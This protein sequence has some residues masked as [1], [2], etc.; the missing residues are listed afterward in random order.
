[1]IEFLV[2]LS[3]YK[4]DI[5]SYDSYFTKLSDLEYGFNKNA[6]YTFK[7]S[8]VSS[9]MVFGLATHNEINQIEHIKNDQ[10]YCQGSYR[11]SQ[12]QFYIISDNERKGQI[13]SKSILIPYVF[14]C[15]TSYNFTLELT[16]KNLKKNLDYRYQNLLIFT[17]IFFI[18]TFIYI[19]FYISASYCCSN[20]FGTNSFNVLLV[21]LFITFFIQD[22]IAY[23]YFNMRDNR[24]YFQKDDDKISTLQIASL[25]CIFFSFVFIFCFCFI[26]Y[27]NYRKRKPSCCVFI[28]F[29]VPI[30]C[31]AAIVPMMLFDN[32]RYLPLITSSLFFIFDIF[33]IFLPPCC[34]LVK[35]GFFVY[36]IGVL[37]SCPVLNMILSIKKGEICANFAIFVAIIVFCVSQALSEFLL[38]INLFIKRVNN[39]DDD[40]GNNGDQNSLIQQPHSSYTMPTIDSNHSTSQNQYTNIADS[41]GFNDQINQNLGLENQGSNPYFNIY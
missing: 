37:L 40:D 31:L 10:Q 26:K 3:Y 19:M 6:N 36:L 15:N 9:K 2:F 1:M 20:S 16:Y 21:F 5:V 12:I 11:L 33:V 18:I 35:F 23:L 7:F 27:L 28:R 38:L 8:S 25:C 39:D 13:P 4:A 32:V 22:S 14:A 29:I 34:N 41:Q 30:V 17:L 24:E